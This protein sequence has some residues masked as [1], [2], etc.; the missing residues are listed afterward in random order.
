[1][2]VGVDSRQKLAARDPSYPAAFARGVLLFRMQRFG[3]ATEAF[4]NH[5]EASPDG[6]YALRAQNHFKAALDRNRQGLF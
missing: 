4:R 6:P 5:L 2:S 1:M 3:P